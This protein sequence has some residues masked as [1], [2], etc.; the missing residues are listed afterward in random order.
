MQRI[1]TTAAIAVRLAAA[2]VAVASGVSSL[3]LAAVRV[4]TANACA[5]PAGVADSADGV[6]QRG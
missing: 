3:E 4:A 1:A 5:V 6:R 2:A